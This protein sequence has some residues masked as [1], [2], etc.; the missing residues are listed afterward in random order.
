MQRTRLVAVPL[1]VATLLTAACG[2]GGGGG[3]KAAAPPAPAPTTAAPAAIPAAYHP[4]IDPAAFSDTI[5]NP[6][7][8]LTPATTRI[9]EGTRDGQ[10]QHA[11]MAVTKETKMIM[12][13]RCVVVRDTVSSNGSLVEGTTDWYA[14]ADNGDVWYFGEDTKEYTNGVVSSTKGS[15]EAGVDGAQPGIIM[16]AKP[17]VGDAY[18]QEYRPGEAEDTAKVARVDPEV[19]VP[20]G[21][22][23]NVVVTEDTNP[24][25]PDFY[26]L[27][28]FASGTGLVYTKRVRTGHQEELSLVKMVK[29]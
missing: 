16:K 4:T 5:T 28:S 6:Y 23:H 29:N 9:Y 3:K 13:V 12:G 8:T 1:A 22:F 27:K 15:W 26:D 10:P 2:S 17:T 11:E 20:A 25:E 24:L 18:R 14:Q 21:T 19:K 7:F